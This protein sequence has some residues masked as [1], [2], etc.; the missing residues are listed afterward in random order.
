MKRKIEI[1][2]LGLL[3]FS[4]ACSTVKNLPAKGDTPASGSVDRTPEEAADVPRIRLM[5]GV[6]A[7]LQ[8]SLAA[9]RGAQAA[10][11]LRETA[12]ERRVRVMYG[13]PSPLKDSLA[14]KAQQ[15]VVVP[16]E[17]AENDKNE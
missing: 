3:G 1:A 10:D 7:P 16:I 6:P 17:P 13:V 4:T 12:P 9:T 2:L 14:Q 8:D 11:T 5:Y 15:Q